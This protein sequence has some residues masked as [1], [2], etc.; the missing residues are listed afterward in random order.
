MK[1]FNFKRKDFKTV[2]AV[3]A[4]NIESVINSL[5][6]NDKVRSIK[7][8]SVVTFDENGNPK[9]GYNVTVVYNE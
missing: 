8:D 1:N 6:E 4:A 2:L 3:Q 7:C 9:F 5:K